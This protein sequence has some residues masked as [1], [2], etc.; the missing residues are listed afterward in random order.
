[1]RAGKLKLAIL[2]GSD[3]RATCQSI[4][5][6]LGLPHAEV[7]AV[8]LDTD[9]P[10]LKRRMKNLR[11][12]VRLEGLSYIWFRLGEAV[13]DS[14]DRLANQIVSSEKTQSL[15]RRAFPSRAFELADFTRIHNIPVIP[16]GNIN[17]SQATEQLRQLDVDL[18]IVL[19]TRILKR[20]T[21]SVPAMGSVNLHKGKVPEYRGQPVGFWEIYDQQSSAGVTVH[22]V[23]EGLDTGDILGEATMQI[24]SKDSPETLRRK[25]D[26]LGSALLAQCISQLAKGTAERRPQLKSQHKT[27]TSPTRK[28]R[29]VVAARVESEKQSQWQRAT[30]TFLYLAFY[31]SG[32]Y[33]LMRAWHRRFPKGRN[34]ILLYHRV[35]DLAQDSLTTSVERFAEHLTLLHE[36]YSVVPT[37]QLVASLKSATSGNSNR[38]AIHFDDCYR[39]VF[40]NAAQLLARMQ[41]PACAFVSSGFV[42]TDRVFRHD[43]EK[44]PFRIEN[45]SAQEVV[46]LIEHGFEVGSHT[47]NHVDL[48]QVSAQEAVIE[49]EKS[50]SDLEEIVGRP[51]DLFSFPYGRRWN[52]RPEVVDIAKRSGYG[53]MF[54]AYG[55]FPTRGSDLYDIRRIGI[56][57]EHR[58]LDLL[59]EIEGLSLSAIKFRLSGPQSEPN[60]AR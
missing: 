20:S 47:V 19:G 25:L 38:I 21:F 41:M 37:V 9:Q 30:K 42:N 43:L 57:G 23:N 26:T 53:A 18:G 16:V 52:I 33:R 39:D 2:T 56:S 5:A 48:G 51:V 29:Y 1:M 32:F 36:H 49:L 44:C 55:G 24:H 54:S 14:L 46:G 7:T 12:N 27:R 31:Y 22:F 58:P 28:E 8:L 45:L 60:G 50:K 10:S 59:M 3:S 35:N 11:R 40:T 34:C 15:L 17:S 6:L 4:E 13:H